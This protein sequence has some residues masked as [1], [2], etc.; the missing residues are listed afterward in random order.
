MND[1]NDDSAI[2]EIKAE[3]TRFALERNWPQFHSPKNLSMAIQ[4]E[5][6]ELAAFFIWE[7]DGN[8]VTKVN[9]KRQA[10][11]EEVAD[12]FIYLLYFS[13]AINCDLINVTKEKLLKNAQKYPVDKSHNNSLK[14]NEF[15]RLDQ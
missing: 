11:C 12:V 7:T 4:V 6:S 3:L 8:S 1:E 9:D 14:Y 5:A 2:R 13:M 10:I 15:P